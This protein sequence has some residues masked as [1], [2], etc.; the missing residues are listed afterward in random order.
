MKSKTSKSGRSRRVKGAQGEREFLSILREL[1]GNEEIERNLTQTRTGGADIAVPVGGTLLEIKRQER[2][3]LPAWL[4]QIKEA[5]SKE[6]AVP[7]LAFR[8]NRTQWRV[9]VELT[10]E[11]YATLIK[12][13]LFEHER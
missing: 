12:S 11:Q 6:G 7:V 4:S 3:S 13:G 10:P 8:Q 5:A 2:L 9:L 1:T